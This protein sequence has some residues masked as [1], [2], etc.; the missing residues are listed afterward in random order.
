[1]HTHAL[2][3]IHRIHL[4]L[5]LS[6]ILTILKTVGTTILLRLMRS[7][8]V[9]L[10]L[11]I[12]YNYPP[13]LCG[14]SQPESFLVDDSACGLTHV[15]SSWQLGPAVAC[16]PTPWC[17]PMTSHY[18]T[19]RKPITRQNQTS[20][21]LLSLSLTAQT[22]SVASSDG[23]RFFFLSLTNQTGSGVRKEKKRKMWVSMIVS[24]KIKEMV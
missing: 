13:K 12:C 21:R 3:N 20:R 15:A 14:H 4:F 2:R 17:H 16:R 23:T 1:M 22:T 18:M 6:T 8:M 24:K 10:L 11:N 19:S 7:L 5:Y 9:D